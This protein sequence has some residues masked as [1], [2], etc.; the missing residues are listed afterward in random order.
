[1]W[2]LVTSHYI[3][4][5]PLVRSMEII[6]KL[7]RLRWLFAIAILLFRR[8]AA[9]YVHS[10]LVCTSIVRFETG[11]FQEAWMTWNLWLFVVVMVS[12]EFKLN[13]DVFDIVG[14]TMRAKITTNATC[15]RLR[16]TFVDGMRKPFCIS[17]F[18]S[19]TAFAFS[20]NYSRRGWELHQSDTEPLLSFW[21]LVSARFGLYQSLA[22]NATHV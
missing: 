11:F 8:S 16:I 17:L 15:S 3:F 20:I 21:G 6:R 2:S 1:M 19:H 14:P 18:A 9:R 10:R 12:G 4:P 7:L 13:T 5:I 22:F